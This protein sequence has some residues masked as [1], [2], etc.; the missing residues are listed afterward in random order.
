MITPPGW[1]VP[2]ALGGFDHGHADAVFHAAERVVEFAFEQD[3]GG[4]LRR[5]C[6]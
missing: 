6:G 5:R 1:S 4:E 3:G 2:S